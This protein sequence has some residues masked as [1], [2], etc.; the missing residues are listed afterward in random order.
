MEGLSGEG[1]GGESTRRVRRP[2]RIVR[3]R[4]ERDVTERVKEEIEEEGDVNAP[5]EL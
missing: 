5:P 1:R 3:D 4:V 2:Y